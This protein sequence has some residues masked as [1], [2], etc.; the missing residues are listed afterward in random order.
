MARSLNKSRIL[1]SKIL[2][3]FAFLSV[4]LSYSSIADESGAHE[5]FDMLGL[6]LVAI[7]ALGRLYTT[8]FLGGKKNTKL[9]THGPFSI[10]RNPLYVFSLLGFTGIAFM[11][12]HITL[13]L[14]VP[15][16]FAILYWNLVQ[17]E[18][19]F[20][21]EKFGDEYKKYMKSVPRFVPNFSKFQ[22]KDEITVNAQ[23][24]KN[25]AM[26]AIWWFSAYP[27]VELAEY[28]RDLGVFAPIV[29]I[30]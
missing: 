3:L 18:E 9:V 4:F 24:L 25:G 20:L 8:A 27:V 17:R 10:V 7:C 21:Q 19:E 5:L 6:F 11:T 30:P 26:D 28:V 22:M 1:V 12:N 29:Y 16:C 15:L 23:L 14:F 2:G 13:M